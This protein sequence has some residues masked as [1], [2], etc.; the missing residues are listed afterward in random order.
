MKNNKIVLT[1]AAVT[2]SLLSGCAAFKDNNLPIVNE[3]DLLSTPDIKT[4]VFTRWSIDTD[5]ELTDTQKA[6]HSAASKERFEEILKGS[7]CCNIVEGPSEADVVVTGKTYIEDH[8]DAMAAAL[9]TGLS[10]YT[11]PSWMTITPKVSA[12]VI[13]GETKHIY[14]FHD[15]MTMVQWLPMIF[16]LPFTGNPI[17]EGEKMENNIFKN[18]LLNIQNDGLFK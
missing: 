6:M 15:S 13:S 9:L 14:S 5:A 11:I 18:L 10:L 16:A 2:L 1:V 7:D 4:K 12:E 17:T 3:A 8:S